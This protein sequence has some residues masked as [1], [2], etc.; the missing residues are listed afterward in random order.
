[1]KNTTSVSAFK[2][3]IEPIRSHGIQGLTLTLNLAQCQKLKDFHSHALVILNT[4]EDKLPANIALQQAKDYIVELM[5]LLDNFTIF[6]SPNDA[7]LF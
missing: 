2:S 3:Y 7:D 5:P 1:M 4:P 6:E